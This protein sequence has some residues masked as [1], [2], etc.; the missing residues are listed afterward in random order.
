MT[1]RFNG[2]LVRLLN[3]LFM[4]IYKFNSYWINTEAYKEM[5]YIHVVPLFF[6][7]FSF[8][9]FDSKD[10]KCR[11]QL[12]CLNLLIMYIVMKMQ[13]PSSSLLGKES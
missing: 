10:K 8:A 13:F 5:F 7:P 11:M 9:H 12:S 2:K 6:F 1:Y 3:N 4:P